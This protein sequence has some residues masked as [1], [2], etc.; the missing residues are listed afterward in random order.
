MSCIL[1]C[2]IFLSFPLQSPSFSLHCT[3]PQ[4]DPN[5]KKKTQGQCSLNCFIM[6]YIYIR[7]KAKGYILQQYCTAQMSV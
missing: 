3:T 1:I 6:Y 4:T 5:F 2:F 7:N